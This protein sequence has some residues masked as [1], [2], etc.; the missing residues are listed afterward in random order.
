M[1]RSAVHCCHHRIHDSK[2]NSLRAYK[3]DDQMGMNDLQRAHLV[4]TWIVTMKET[5]DG[6]DHDDTS[7]SDLQMR[8]LKEAAEDADIGAFACAY[9]GAATG[10][11]TKPVVLSRSQEDRC[12]FD[13]LRR[14]W[15]RS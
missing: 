9:A 3:I 7:W 13:R 15:Y 5:I 2:T 10:V 12:C 14:A 8:R 6:C 11:V 4:R 1:T